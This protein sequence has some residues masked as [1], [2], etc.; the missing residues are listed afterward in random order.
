VFK[1]VGVKKS[2]RICRCCLT[3]NDR[4]VI[5]NDRIVVWCGTG[6]VFRTVRIHFIQIEKIGSENHR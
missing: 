2:V 5:G 4:S 6:T 3:V 1:L